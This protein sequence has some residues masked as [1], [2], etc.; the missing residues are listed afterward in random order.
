[1]YL[2]SNTIA[3]LLKFGESV[4]DIAKD[5]LSTQWP[6]ESSGSVSVRFCVYPPSGLVGMTVSLVEDVRIVGW[7]VG[8]YSLASGNEREF[9]A[10]LVRACVCGLPLEYWETLI[11]TF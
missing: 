3:R 5:Q 4:S 7:V 6:S 1:M 9:F 8:Y 11:V 2:K 10:I